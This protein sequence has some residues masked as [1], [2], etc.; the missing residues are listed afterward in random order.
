MLETEVKFSV[1]AS[2]VLPDLGDHAPAEKVERLPDQELKATYYDTPDLRLARSGVTLRYRTGDDSV[3]AWHLKLPVDGGDGRTRQELQFD[4]EARSI[5][6]EI[7]D[8]ITVFARSSDVAAVESIH[9]RR[10]RWSVDAGEERVLAELV[11]DEVSVMQRG[12]VVTRFRELELEQRD[13]SPD[14]FGAMIERLQ[15][16]G[17]QEVEPIPKVVRVL[18]PAATAPSD[19]PELFDMDDEATGADLVRSALVRGLHR[20]VRHDPPA[21]QGDAE[22]VHQMRVAARRMRSDLGTFESLVDPSWSSGLIDELRWLGDELGRVRDLDV[23]RE[24]LERDA[25]DAGS[26]LIPLFNRLSEG[27]AAA[28]AELQDTLKGDR[29]KVLL[30][31]LIEAAKSPS[32]TEVASRKATDLG[33]ELVAS[34]WRTLRKKAGGLHEDSPDED[35]H[36]VRIKAKKARYAAEAV[37]ATLPPSKAK[38]AVRFAGRAERLQE[39]L[40]EL[41][42]AAVAQETIL[43][44]LKEAGKD[45]KLHFEAGR[46]FEKQSHAAALS[47][48]SFEPAWRK[49]DKRK[50]LSWLKDAG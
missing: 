35:L 6:D 5:P 31:R 45:P 39:V 37:T 49:L 14:E 34:A 4:G 9:T 16:A 21:R 17:A 26:A 10:R 3:P 19:F 20:L 38:A 40:G 18:G 42:D 50:S 30:D 48:A 12:R 1:H 32:L 33:P 8:L 47:R 2:F 7:E 29:Y 44:C 24:R 28:R 15:A 25:S 11:D 43:A 41:Q 27:H 36:R 46:L 22:G 23:L 13:A